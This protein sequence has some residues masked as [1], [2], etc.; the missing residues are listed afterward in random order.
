MP[1]RQQR[2]R[3]HRVGMIG[4]P[5]PLQQEYD[6]EPQ[7]RREQ[8]Q[9]CRIDLVVPLQEHRRHDRRAP[10]RQ[11]RLFQKRRERQANGNIHIPDQ[12]PDDG[13]ELRVERD[14][15]C[16]V[17]QAY[18]GSDQAF[19]SKDGLPRSQ[20]DSEADDGTNDRNC[21][22]RLERNGETGAAAGDDDH[23]GR[24]GFFFHP[25]GKHGEQRQQLHNSDV[26]ALAECLHRQ[27]RKRRK[28]E[29]RQQPAV[30]VWK[31]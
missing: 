11:C 27:D 3:D 7:R 17:E 14:N 24:W 31:R 25:H 30:G 26:F 23:P 18:G 6:S 2:Q 12:R 22:L 21:K 29:R 28:C 19:R 15:A 5:L 13:K 9:A 20:I 8:Q 4:P 10:D 1:E 16:G